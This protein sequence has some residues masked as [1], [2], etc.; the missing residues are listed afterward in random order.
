VN[1][2]DIALKVRADITAATEESFEHLI[3]TNLQG[4]YFLT[5]AVANHRLST[6]RP[7]VSVKGLLPKCVS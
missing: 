3:R 6:P 4:P 2:A 1:N 7:V 5:Q